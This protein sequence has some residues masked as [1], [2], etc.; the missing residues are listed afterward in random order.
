VSPEFVSFLHFRHRMLLIR[1]WRRPADVP[2]QSDERWECQVGGFSPLDSFA[3]K[4][5]WI[6]IGR[7]A[8]LE[9]DL[10]LVGY[11]CLSSQS[12]TRCEAQ[13]DYIYR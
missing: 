11:Q 4:Y 8:G 1:V 5:S 2:L 10:G 7:V 6:R 12:F 9:A 13:A 3:V